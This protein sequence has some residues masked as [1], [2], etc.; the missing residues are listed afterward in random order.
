MSE[1][2]SKL[3]K[4]ITPYKAGEQPQDKTYIKLNTNENPYPP[5][6]RVAEVFYGMAEITK[7]SKFID[8]EASRIAAN[9][10]KNLRLYSDPNNTLLKAALAKKY[11]L[12]SFLRWLQ[13][14]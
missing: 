8:E 9:S 1:F 12:K 10:Y 5:S 7:A 2:L 6:P 4:N 13:R 3:A 11:N 14:N